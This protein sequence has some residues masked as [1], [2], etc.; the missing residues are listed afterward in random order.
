MSIFS[1]SGDW[2]DFWRN[3][4]VTSIIFIANTVMLIAV[5]VTGGFNNGTV[6]NWAFINHQLI[7][8][9]GEYYRLISGAFHHWSFLHY[10]FN[11]VIGVIVLS[12]ALERI[13]GSKRF[14]VIYFGSLLISSFIAAFLV[15]NPLVRSAGA[16]GAIFGVL[17]CLL[18]ISINRKDLIDPQDI[19]SIFVLVAFQVIST[20][21]TPGVSVHAHVSGLLGGFLL[22]FLVIKKPVFKVLH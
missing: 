19:Q 20:F 21:L 10:G 15:T 22:S 2:R 12:S 7:F 4:P 11:M 5:L 16:S 1:R 3:S 13:L 18:W 9:Q 17:G 6:S 8:D 14:S